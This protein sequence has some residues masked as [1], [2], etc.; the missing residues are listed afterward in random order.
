MMHTLWT[1]GYTKNTVMTLQ[2]STKMLHA[3]YMIYKNMSVY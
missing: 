3:M 1:T 2:P